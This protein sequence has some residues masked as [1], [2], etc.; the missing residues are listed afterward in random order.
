MVELNRAGKKVDLITMTTKVNILSSDQQELSMIFAGHLKKEVAFDTLND[1]QVIR[2]SLAQVTCEVVNIHVEGDH[3]LFIGKV[4]NIELE[5][6]D[7]LL[8]ED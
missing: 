2:C 7:L 8:F 5:E 6:K 4:K 1:L 3:S